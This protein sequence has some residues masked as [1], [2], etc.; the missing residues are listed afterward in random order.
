MMDVSTDCGGRQEIYLNEDVA[1]V[2]L[3]INPCHA[4]RVETL[5]RKADRKLV[6]N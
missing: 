4:M 2:D 1:C 3:K 5:C 6:C